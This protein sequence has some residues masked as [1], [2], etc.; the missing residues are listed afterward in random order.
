MH[1]H[2]T[3]KYLHFIS[4]L[5]AIALHRG[6]FVQTH[7]LCFCPTICYCFFLLVITASQILFPKFNYTSNYSL[8]YLPVPFTQNYR[9][10]WIPPDI[11][12]TSPNRLCQ[13]IYSHRFHSIHQRNV[14]NNR[15]LFIQLEKRIVPVYYSG[16]TTLKSIWWKFAA[17]VLK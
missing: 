6:S 14:V 9:I 12:F 10:P 13:S 2:S 1:L 8:F 15:I 7:L 16:L 4:K 5:F 3:Y 11:L 17:D